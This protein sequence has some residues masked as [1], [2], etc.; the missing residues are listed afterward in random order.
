MLGFKVKAKR[1]V[2]FA[3]EEVEANP[4]IL[5]LPVSSP[6]CDQSSSMPL[7]PELGV[8]ASFRRRH[9]CLPS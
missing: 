2:N 4:A 3:S 5:T 1:K 8:P 6:G 7:E 9:S